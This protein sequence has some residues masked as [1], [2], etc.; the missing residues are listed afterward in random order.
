L[1]YSKEMAENSENIANL[2]DC[3]RSLRQIMAS[4]DAIELTAEE[5]RARRIHVAVAYL[6][7]AIDLL[8]EA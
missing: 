7:Q 2:K 8:D 3:V 5:P 4:A 6:Q 1:G